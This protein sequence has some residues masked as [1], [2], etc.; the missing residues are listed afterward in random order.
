M[1]KSFF[2]IMASFL[3]AFTYAQVGVGTASPNSTLDV[4]G[5]VAT[6]Y[7]AFTAS[8]SAAST[9]NLLVFTGSS[10]ATLTLPTAVGCDG[11]NYMI[12]NASTSGTTPLLTIATTS[13]QTIDGIT[14]WLLDEANETITLVSNGANWNIVAQSLASGSGTDWSQGGNSVSSLK[15]IGTISNYSLPFITNNTEKMR[16]TSSGNLGIGTST[17]NGTYPEKLLVDAGTTTSVN[18]I[19]G[20]GSIDSYLQLN[21]QNNSSGASASSDVVATANN[22]S[23]TTNY[24]DMGI[25][26]GSNASGIMG[27]AND[28]YLYNIGQNLLVGTGTAAKSLVFMTGGTTQAT[29]ER[30]RVDGNGKVGIGTNAIPKGTIGAA[31]FAIE[32]TTASTSGPHLQ[33]TTS[34]DNY[35]LAQFLNWQHDNIYQT[36][37]AYYDGS[38]KSATTAGGNFVTGKES[39]KLLFQYAAVNTQGSAITWNNG[40]ALTNA[41]KVGI[42]TSTFNATYPEKL[43]VDAGTT[44]S[45]NAIVGKGSIDSYLQLNI[46]NSSSGASASSDVVATA[47]NGSETTNYIDMGINGG[48]NASGVMGVA[49]DAYL[50]NIGQNLLVGTG[51]ATK[52]LVF[53][54]GGTTQASNERMRVDGSGNVGIG[55]NAPAQKFH[56]SGGNARITNG[57]INA[58]IMV[59]T[60]FGGVTNAA[61]MVYYEISGSETHMFG[62]EIIPDADNSRLCGS[63]ARRWSAVYAA[64]GTIQTSDFRMKKNIHELPYG[65]KEVMQMKPVAYN[66]KDNTGGN[67]I[68]LIAQEIRKIIPEVVLGD[69]S[70]ENL[71]MNYAEMIPVLIN[72]IKEQQKQID[73]LKKEILTIKG[74]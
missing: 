31:K 48:S 59:G 39:G 72:A 15:N 40:I 10:A 66:W 26:G 73:D 5:S 27:V 12:K 38:W 62:G 29:N 4:R 69:E 60:T 71:G 30:M 34:S 65:L 23:E 24:I 22:G 50:Y 2:T 6:N 74:K 11:R 8:T 49:N 16:L 13:S 70:K 21:I 35:P 28:A 20:K 25:N 68:G 7:R 19:V 51:T 58:D 18:A 64:N 41:G 36:Y 53:M 42:G 14:T 45:V 1:K 9:D 67:K 32:G 61:G 3:A 33:F 46:Q 43:L 47:N 55:T 17:F 37:D 52:S 57:G 56:L 63:S 54:T 44:T